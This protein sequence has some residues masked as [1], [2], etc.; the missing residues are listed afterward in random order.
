M[1]FLG[2]LMGLIRRLK[3]C[4]KDSTWYDIYLLILAEIQRRDRG[5]VNRGHPVFRCYFD[6]L[7]VCGIHDKNLTSHLPMATFIVHVVLNKI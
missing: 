7:I 5:V 3:L 6:L 2:S 1:M 4:M